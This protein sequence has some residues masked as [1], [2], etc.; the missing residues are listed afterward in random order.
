MIDHMSVSVGDFAVSKAFY[1]AALAP[2]AFQLLQEIPAAVTGDVDA[3][4][5]GEAGDGE[6]WITGGGPTTPHLHLAFRVATAA[7]VDGF[8]RAALAA[9]GRDN[10]APGIRAVYHPNY[11]AAFVLDP[12]G[13]NIEAVCFLKE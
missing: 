12:D 13:H 3:A 6:F 11:Y 8:H 9:G 1:K 4:G 10:G 2:L 7:M 5:F